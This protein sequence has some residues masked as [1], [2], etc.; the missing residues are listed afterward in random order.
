MKYKILGKSGLKVSEICLGTMTFGT[1]WQIGEDK[2]H[3][4]K[5]FNKYV[6]MGGN[7]LDT[8]DIYTQ[9]TSEKWVGE[10]IRAKRDEFV[11]ATKYTNCIPGRDVN[12]S[13]N[14]RKNMI[15][16]VEESLLRLKTDYIDLFWMHA[17]DGITPI[18]EV[19]RSFD[20]LVTSGKVR[21]IG[22]SDTPAWYVSRANTMA[23]LK[24]WTSFIGLQ[25]EYSLIERTVERELIP[26]AKELGIAIM[27]W[28]PLG[29][30]LL[31]GKYTSGKKAKG[32]LATFDSPLLNEKNLKIAKTVD[33]VA[34]I[35][36]VNS[37]AVALRWVIEQGTVPIIGA[38]NS[39][40]LT[41]SLKALDIELTR[42]Q[43]MELDKVSEIEPGFPEKFLNNSEAR[44]FIHGGH[45]D[46]IDKK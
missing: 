28:S 33:K 6:D 21:Y 45:Y 18:E 17:Y 37:S 38:R 35:Q 29:R 24:D 9:G 27:P 23:E 13:G 34:E 22:I 46:K 39:K 19:M 4:R 11:L 1:E 30:G 26:M 3:S 20:D 36:G 41:E 15:R 2:E 25:V 32:R 7:F 42:K 40:Q 14:S 31:T 44:N 16:S 5:V 12:K 43:L 10:F 8:A